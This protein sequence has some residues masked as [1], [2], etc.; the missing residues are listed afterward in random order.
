MKVG[1]RDSPENS[2]RLSP[3]PRETFGLAC[4]GEQDRAF[5]P[6]KE[7]P[8][9]IREIES[10][11]VPARCPVRPRVRGG[12][13]QDVFSWKF[14]FKFQMFDDKRKTEPRQI[15]GAYLGGIAR[16]DARTCCDGRIKNESSPLCGRRGRSMR[17]DVARDRCR[18]DEEQS[19]V[20]SLSGRR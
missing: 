19:A 16:H 12:S 6:R 20:G 11:T 10:A 4:P 9:K 7:V 1:F 3:A 8:T 14:R 17:A 5:V 2:R 18:L 13:K 15:R